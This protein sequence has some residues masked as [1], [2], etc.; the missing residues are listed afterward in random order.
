MQA[1]QDPDYERGLR[2]FDQLLFSHVGSAMSNAA[3]SFFLAL[4]HAKL[5]DTPIEGSTQRYYQHINRYSAA[6]A[7]TADIAML[8]LGGNLKRRESLSA[9]LGDVFSSIYL[10][11][12]V[13]KHY[14]DQGRPESDLP[15][16]EWSCRTLLYHAQE[17]LHGF[18]RNFPNRFVAATLRFCLFPRGRTYFAPSDALGE[19]IVKLITHPTAARARLCAGIYKTSGPG[20]PLGQLQDALEMAEQ[21]TPLENKIRDAERAGVITGEHPLDKIDQAEKNG[22]LT[23]EE[24]NQLRIYDT[25]V[26]DLIAVDEFDSRE[27]GTKTAAP[28]RSTK[29]TASKSG[30]GRAGK[31]RKKVGNPKSSTAKRKSSKS[32]ASRSK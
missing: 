4:T 2:E 29:K 25:K 23:K 30:A 6:F 31:A 19:D 14:E 16:V 21:M 11:S 9:R 12:L 28:K 5:S 15:L 3:R 27:L 26:M 18:L 13:L 8:V 17:Q 20:N 32:K 1:A 22:I 24:A 10:A 7:L